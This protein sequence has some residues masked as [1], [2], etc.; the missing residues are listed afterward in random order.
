[1]HTVGKSSIQLAVNPEVAQDA[2]RTPRDAIDPA[3]DATVVLF[4]DEDVAA[5]DELDTLAVVRTS[6]EVAK[7]AAQA[8]LEEN[9]PVHTVLD[10]AGE[11]GC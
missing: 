4:V 1:V 6:W 5:L 3:F 8:S 2:T 9:E 11:G 7:L 10:E